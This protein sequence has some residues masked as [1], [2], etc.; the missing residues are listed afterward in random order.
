MSVTILTKIFVYFQQYLQANASALEYAT[1]PVCL[2]FKMRN[3][4]GS[5]LAQA[6]GWWITPAPARV[7]TRVRPC[8]IHDRGSGKRY[9]SSEDFG[10]FPES[11]S[12]NLSLLIY[13]PGLVHWAGYRPSNQVYFVSPHPT[14]LKIYPNFKTCTKPQVKLETCIF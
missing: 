10:Y 7:R 6:A 8:V 13:H 5:D 11:C 4:A 14:Q 9:N 12:I 1:I 3:K 2:K